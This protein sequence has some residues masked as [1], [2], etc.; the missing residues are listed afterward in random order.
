[1]AE[2][3]NFMDLLFDEQPFDDRKLPRRSAG[4]GHPAAASNLPAQP[5][6]LLLRGTSLPGSAASANSSVPQPPS[7]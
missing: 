2:L 5:Y 6:G 7:A 1:M 3:K 4:P